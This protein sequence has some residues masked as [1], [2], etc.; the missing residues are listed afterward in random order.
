MDARN[1][2]AHDENSGGQR[3]DFERIIFGQA[4]SLHERIDDA[5]ER[6][7]TLGMVGSVLLLVAH[8]WCADGNGDGELIRIISARKATRQERQAYEQGD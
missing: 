6:W 4:L 5:E 8:T 2:S 1:K 7:Q 3:I